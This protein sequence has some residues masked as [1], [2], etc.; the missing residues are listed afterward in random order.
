MFTI[1]VKSGG[2]RYFPEGVGRS[3]SVQAAVFGPHCGYVEVAYDLVA[4]RCK[5]FDAVSVENCFV[6]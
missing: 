1:D 3:A 4:F 2:V 5:L 6:I